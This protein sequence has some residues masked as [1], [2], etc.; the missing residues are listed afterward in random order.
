M[1]T[2]I[3]I[4]LCLCATAALI[5]CYCIRINRPRTKEEAHKRFMQDCREFDAYMANKKR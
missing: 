5:G 4:V 1:P 2:W 3:V